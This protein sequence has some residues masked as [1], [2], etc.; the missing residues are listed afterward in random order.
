MLTE[1]EIRR[2]IEEDNLSEKKRRA[3][4]GQ[5]YYEGDHDIL[6]YR[7][8]YYN[9]DGVLVEDKARSN[10]RICHPFFTEHVDQLAAYIMSFEQNPIRA[11][12]AADGLQDH[13]DKLLHYHFHIF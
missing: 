2:F 3:R 5:R 10:S 8:F 4:E 1:S 6:Q 9:A 11:K 7:V 13:L 12:D